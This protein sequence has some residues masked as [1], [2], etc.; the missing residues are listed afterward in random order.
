MIHFFFEENPMK[1]SEPKHEL[2]I[3][4]SS[5]LYSLSRAD[6]TENDFKEIFKLQKE[7]LGL[8]FIY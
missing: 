2:Q 3:P 1:S 4:S 7:L 6:K 5:R 8:A